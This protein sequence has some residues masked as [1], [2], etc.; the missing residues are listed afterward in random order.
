[1]DD[2]QHLKRPIIC[3]TCGFIGLNG[4]LI[5]SDRSPHLHCPKCGG[6]EIE[7]LVH[8]APSQVS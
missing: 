1:M 7:Y 8:D 6:H 4:D 2:D 5:A 3:Q